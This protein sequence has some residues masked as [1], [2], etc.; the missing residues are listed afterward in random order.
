M[1]QGYGIRDAVPDRLFVALQVREGVFGGFGFQEI[2][3]KDFR[4]QISD[5]R[6]ESGTVT[7]R[8]S[9]CNLKAAMLL[10]RFLLVLLLSRMVLVNRVLT[11]G[12]LHFHGDVHVGLI[13]VVVIA[14]SLKTLSQDLNAKLAVRD[15]IVAGLSLRVGLQLES[16][17]LLLTMLIHRVHHH[18]GVADGLAVL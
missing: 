15:A 6:L 7:G 10:L 14:V 8:S 17:T 4:L 5:C 3:H 16:A 9:I 2:V 13:H 11:S 12:A 18:G 1:L